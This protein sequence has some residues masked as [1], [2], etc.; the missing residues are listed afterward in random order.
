MIDPTEKGL[1]V[2]R[3]CRMLG[4]C[5]SSRYYKRKPIKP[6][7][8]ELMRLIDEQ[9]LKTPSWGSRSMRNY[10]RRR[11]YKVN[12]K[13]VQRLMRLM[14]LEAIY[15][16]PKTSRPHPGHKLYPYLLRNLN[17]DRPN[18]VWAADVTYIPMAR[19]FMYLVVVMDWHSRKVLSWRLS[20]TLEA[21]FC[22]EALEDA[23]SRHGCPEIFN[24]DQG[25]QF[26][27]QAFTGVLKSHEIQISMD[28]RGRVQDNIFIERLWWSIKYQYLYLWSFDNGAQ[29]R[30]GLDQWF[31]LYNQERSHQ[32]LDN[33]TPDEVYYGLP[34]P[35]V[36]AA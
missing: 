6:D 8:L 23:L 25:A 19:G 10:L 11:G 36:Q 14:G 2:S 7:G 5:R 28:G 24:T 12:R 32:A 9:Y 21:D 34:H 13:R 33:L 30:Q 31:Q 20:N 26:T 22:V 17:I 1:S 29:L 27:S 16:K 4:I 15:P 18:K 35:F 3:Q